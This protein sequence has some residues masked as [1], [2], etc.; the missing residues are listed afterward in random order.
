MPGRTLAQGATAATL[1]SY[2][3][4][5]ASAAGLALLAPAAT[6]A[7]ADAPAEPPAGTDAPPRFMLVLHGGAGTIRRADMTPAQDSAYR[8]TL[9][10]AIRAGYDVLQGGGP[11]LDA[12]TAVIGIVDLV[13]RRYFFTERRWESLQRIRETERQQGRGQAR[14][15]RHRLDEDH[16]TVGVVALDGGGHL[17]AGTSTGTSCA[18]WSPTTSAPA[19]G[20]PARVYGDEG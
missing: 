4:A 16:G 10:R 17:A 7:Q 13:P 20:T 14:L 6:A 3:R 15:L 8:S 11:A 5:A 12:V 9:T 2:V 19:C 18:T 1:L